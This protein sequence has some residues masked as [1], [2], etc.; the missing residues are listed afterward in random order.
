MYDCAGGNVSDK[1]DDDDG[2]SD[3]KIDMLT[4]ENCV[5]PQ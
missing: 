5:M 2:N 3:N 4:Q 1:D